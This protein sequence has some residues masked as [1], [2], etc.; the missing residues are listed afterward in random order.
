MVG[1]VIKSECWRPA[2]N[3]LVPVIVIIVAA[4]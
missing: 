1:T 2:A 4:F 3:Y